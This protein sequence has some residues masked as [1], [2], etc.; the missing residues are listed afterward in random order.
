MAP[1]AGKEASGSGDETLAAQ[2]DPVIAVTERE[3]EN[4]INLLYFMGEYCAYG[5]RKDDLYCYCIDPYFTYSK[6]IEF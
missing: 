1:S 6:E 2:L 4:A 5:I 3:R